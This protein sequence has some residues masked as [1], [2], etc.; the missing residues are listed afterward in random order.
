MKNKKIIAIVLSLAVTIILAGVIGLFLI[1]HIF[2]AADT[3][4]YLIDNIKFLSSSEDVIEKF[5]QPDSDD[6]IKEFGNYRIL[7]Y[8]RENLFGSDSKLTFEYNED[9]LYGI[10]IV[11]KGDYE[12][13]KQIYNEKSSQ[14]SS[15]KDIESSVDDYA[16]ENAITSV[17][18]SIDYGATGSN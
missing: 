14:L 11:I 12:K 16:D 13:L 17:N 5:G 18:Y 9:K 1:Y 7:T 8:N 10:G 15:V 4:T 2:I 3:N 6:F